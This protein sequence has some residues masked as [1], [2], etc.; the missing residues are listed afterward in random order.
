MQLL[1]LMKQLKNREK[2]TYPM[3]VRGRGWIALILLS[4]IILFPL[5][6]CGKVYEVKERELRIR[7]VNLSIVFEFLINRDPEARNLKS[8]KNELLVKIK[9]TEGELQKE[10]GGEKRIDLKNNLEGFRSELKKIKEKENYFKRKFLNEIDKAIS[11]LSKD[12]HIDFVLNMGDALIFSQKEY[13]ITEDV[14]REIIK[15]KKRRDPVS[16]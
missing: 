8:Q 4:L 16:R 12:M 9:D 15:L 1:L 11:I 7:Y 10:G 14:I 2:R 6:G 13:D 3:L 5:A